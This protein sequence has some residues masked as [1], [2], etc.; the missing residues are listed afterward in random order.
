MPV[1]SCQSG[2]SHS[3]TDLTDGTSVKSAATSLRRNQSVRVRRT[4]ALPLTATAAAARSAAAAAAAGSSELI[5]R[6]CRPLVVLVS[7]RVICLFSCH[8][9]QNLLGSVC[10]LI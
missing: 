4:S 10:L 2:H 9:F 7:H 6:R 8:V 1:V 3:S 5:I